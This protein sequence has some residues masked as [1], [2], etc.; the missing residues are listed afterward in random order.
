MSELDWSRLRSVT[1][2]EI[3]A[4]LLRDGFSLRSR[5]GSHR[6][7]RHA[8]GRRVTVS[9]HRQSDT[10]RP[11]TLRSIIGQAGWGENDL[12]RLKLLK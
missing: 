10:F 9:C 8:D 11:K 5:A 6:R 12:R 3:M 1:A 4:A 7:Y 2:R